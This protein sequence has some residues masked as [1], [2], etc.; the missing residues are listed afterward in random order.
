MTPFRARTHNN[1]MLL[2]QG[3]LNVLGALLLLAM[4]PV[5]G[6][7][8]SLFAALSILSGILTC[9]LVTLRRTAVSGLG[10]S[11]AFAANLLPVYGILWFGHVAWATQRAHWVAFEPHG[12]SA[13]TIAILAPPVRWIGVP[14]I[15][16]LPALAAL[17]YATFSPETV[18]WIVPNRP[19]TAPIAFAA[20]AVV[21]YFFR[22]RGLRIAELAARKAAEARMARRMTRT[23]LTIKDLA[24]SPIQSLALDAEN[25]L[26]R[27]PGDASIGG[28]V[29]RAAV[30][31]REL[32]RVLDEQLRASDA[33]LE[34]SLD[35]REELGNPKPWGPG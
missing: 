5:A 16:L 26:R 22:L 11:L 10:A 18:G 24:N 19:L 32:N 8:Q 7:G 12:L 4:T 30:R 6:P 20:F 35:S 17:Q 31:L 25:L 28:R 13:L 34:M 15:L 1:N 33:E 2:A 3:V 29:R 14:A 9:V 21:L 23:V 27:H